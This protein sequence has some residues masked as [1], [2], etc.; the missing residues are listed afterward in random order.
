MDGLDLLVEL[1]Q[2]LERLAACWSF[3]E[4]PGKSFKLPLKSVEERIRRCSAESAAHFG[5]ARN[6]FRRGRR[7]ERSSINPFRKFRYSLLQLLER[8][9]TRQHRGEEIPDIL[10]LGEN[11]SNRLWVDGVRAGRQ[12]L[13]QLRNSAGKRANLIARRETADRASKRPE[14]FAHESNLRINW[15]D[16]G[17]WRT[18][19]LDIVLLQ[20]FEPIRQPGNLMP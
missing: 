19:R 7:T 1:A 9:R 3:V 11:A 4:L 15:R 5:D 17:H 16:G 18:R 2:A 6:Y 8:K 10:G 13:A 14:V 20:E 12:F